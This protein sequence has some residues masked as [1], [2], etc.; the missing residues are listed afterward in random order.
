MGLGDPVI[1]VA[2]Q[3]AQT[4]GTGQ[5]CITAGHE[6]AYSYGCMCSNF[7]PVARSPFIIS[8]AHPWQEPHAPQHQ[9]RS[10]FIASSNKFATIETS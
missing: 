1:E 8:P 7:H 4:V 2:Q 6:R 5:G 3:H 9:D 10:T